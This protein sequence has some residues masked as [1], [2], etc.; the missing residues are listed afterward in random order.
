MKVVFDSYLL[1]IVDV[2]AEV[3][4]DVDVNFVVAQVD[5]DLGSL[6]FS[7]RFCVVDGFLN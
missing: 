5:V 7:F 3:D 1:F 4:I 6:F 2:V